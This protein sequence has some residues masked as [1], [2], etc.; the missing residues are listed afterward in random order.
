MAAP[1][2]AVLY[3]GTTLTG[4]TA[5][6]LNSGGANFGVAG[7]VFSSPSYSEVW[8]ASPTWTGDGEAGLTIST[9]GTGSGGGAFAGV[10]QQP[11]ASTSTADGYQVGYLWG[12]TPKIEVYRYTNGGGTFVTIFSQ[13]VTA[14]AAG[15]AIAV[16]VIGGTIY[17][18]VRRSGTWSLVGSVADST[19][20]FSGGGA[21]CEWAIFDNNGVCRV[22]NLFGGALVGGTTQ[23][24][25]T[26]RLNYGVR[27]QVAATRRLSYGVLAQVAGTRRLVYGVRAQ[28]SAT[29]R[30]AYAVLATAV[31]TRRLVYGVQG[32]TT[33]VS[34]TRRVNY[35]VIAQVAA[36]RRVSYGVQ[37]GVVST[38]RVTYN[39]VSN[40]AATRRLTYS[41]TANVAGTRR[42]SYLVAGTATAA[43]S[44]LPLSGVGR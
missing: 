20:T 33:Q 38:R 6:P 10:I 44:V 3:D 25:A 36:T 14:L 30:L 13:T 40:V 31:G 18:W 23:V 43:V 11:S 26:R 12:A 2:T 41:V 16:Q 29:R 4:L 34:A 42:V 22:D 37:A 27:A 24:S 8:S 35:L 5:N 17:A 28:V 7:G 9:I 15:D 39:V 21:V 19:F 32:P 1:S